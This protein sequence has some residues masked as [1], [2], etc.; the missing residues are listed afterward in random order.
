MSSDG[1]RRSVE[2][3]GRGVR[4]ALACGRFNG[5]LTEQL[6]VR[7]R[8]RLVE[9]GVIDTDVVEVWAPGAFEL[10]LVA[11]ALAATGCHD[12]VV[13][14]GA[15][16][17]GDT[18]HFEFVA[19]ECAAGVSRVALE[20]GVPVVFGVLTTENMQQ[21]TE[22]ADPHGQDKGGEFAEAAVEMACLLRNL[23]GK[24]GPRN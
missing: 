10:P 6:R 4:V 12:A 1:A 22:R 17:R 14:L 9:L 16:V 23:S 8:E 11:K 19:G 15:V 13:T 24:P 2:L 21:A 3:D 7:C 20:T 5:D 18:P